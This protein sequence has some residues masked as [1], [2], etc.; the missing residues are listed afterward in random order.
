MWI[1]L[2]TMTGKQQ[3]KHSL[4]HSANSVDTADDLNRI[5]DRFD[6]R[7]L[8]EDCASLYETIVPEQLDLSEADLV[9]SFSRL[10]SHKAWPRWTERY[11]SEK[12]CGS[13]RESIIIFTLTVQLFLDLHV[14]PRA[15]KTS[16]IIAVPEKA[17]PLQPND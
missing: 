8:S 10:N 3:T 13:A 2:R 1:G 14:M 9:T 11:D 16:T 15:W 5:Y 6:V 7:Q 4:P 17:T 12:L